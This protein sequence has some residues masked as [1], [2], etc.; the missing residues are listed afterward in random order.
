MSSARLISIIDE[1]KAVGVKRPSIHSPIVNELANKLHD[2]E[3]IG[4]VVYGVYSGGTGF[5]WIVATSHRIMVL[6]KKPLYS[7]SDEISYE[8]VSGV[9]YTR[10]SISSS[11]TL[12]TR[13]GDYTIK[14]V[15]PTS[16]RTFIA[17]IEERL[18][19]VNL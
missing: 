1:L 9:K 5:A 6:D 17:Y 15:K 18:E 4:G 14:Y 7:S 2:D 3:Q 16:A 12:H 10:A 11:V 8:V 13:V 19:K